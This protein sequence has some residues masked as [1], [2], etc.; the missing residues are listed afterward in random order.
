M[1]LGISAWRAF[2]DHC[3]AGNGVQVHLLVFLRELDTL[4]SNVK[5]LADILEICGR[6]RVLGVGDRYKASSAYATAHTT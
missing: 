3:G 1:G 5:T 2:L 4:S 6:V